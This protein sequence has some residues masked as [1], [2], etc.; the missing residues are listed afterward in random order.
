MS[1]VLPED[2]I[3]EIPSSYSIIGHIG[4]GFTPIR[5]PTSLEN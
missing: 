5:G 4:I 3:E 2:E 1:V